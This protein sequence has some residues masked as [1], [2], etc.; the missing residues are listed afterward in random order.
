[1]IYWVKSMAAQKS[2]KS[3]SINLLPKEEFTTS[4]FGRILKWLL[5]TF[6]IIVIVVEM[7]V[8]AA[9]LSRFWLDARSTDLNDQIKQRQS[10]IKSFEGFEQSFRST[11][12]KL[13]VFAATTE[14]KAKT[15]PKIETITSL[16]PSEVVLSSVV[17]N[18]D[19][20]QIKANTFGEI[21]IAQYIA[22]LEASDKFKEVALQQVSSSEDN[23]ITFIIKLTLKE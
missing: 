2:K 10:A 1:M 15:L 3:Q 5:S 7:V 19:S 18:K 12:A 20:I 6:R 21:S 22:N 14:D 16:L 17:L 13:A 9:F 23:N 4:I 8:M 11:Q